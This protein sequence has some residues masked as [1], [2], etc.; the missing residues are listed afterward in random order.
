MYIAVNVL[1]ILTDVWQVTEDRVA[2]L[3]QR[4][5][6]CEGLQKQQQVY[7]E[8]HQ[9]IRKVK[10]KVQKRDLQEDNFKVGDLVLQKNKR[11]E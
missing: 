6:V 5:A 7:S 2:R 11:V 8:V 1:Y 9:N 10:D 4:E 3:L